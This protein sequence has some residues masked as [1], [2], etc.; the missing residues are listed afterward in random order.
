MTHQHEPTRAS[1]PSVWSLPFGSFMGLIAVNGAISLFSFGVFIKPLE[2]EFGWDRASISSAIALCAFASALSVPLVGTLMDRFGVR[3]VMIT[4]I[5]LF[6]AN[7]AAIGLSGS[8]VTFVLLTA[9]T[10]VTGVGQGPIGYVKSISSYFDRYR[11]IAIGIAISG[12]GVGTAFVPLYTQWLIGHVGW[13]W[14]YA[15]LGLVLIA[16]AWPAV[17]FFIREPDASPIA[18]RARAR[19]GV[20][21]ALPGATAREA[22]ASRTFWILICTIFFVSTVVNGSIVHVVS[23]L[24]DR[25][26]SAEAAA[27]IMVWVG[28]AS[29]VGRLVVGYLL[30]RMFAPYVAIGL[31]LA[32]L[33]GLYLL[34]SGKNAYLG[35]SGIGLTGG[36]EIDVI[37]YM[38]S[39]YFGLRRFGQI[40]GYQFGVFLVGAGLGP[41]LMGAAQTR[42]HSY[43]LPFQA[44][45]VL[46]VLASLL[47]LLMGGYTYPTEDL[48]DGDREPPAFPAVTAE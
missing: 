41:M 26:W 36:A 34:A 40:Y 28:L 31:F 22:I 1:G 5:F 44:F 14:A 27:A 25:G 46:L 32:A 48:R 33:G 8:I 2:A 35:V 30:D 29:M 24:T 20:T 15:G 19:A 6:A 37:A 42:L 12:T 39:R 23:L 17:M 43:D 13:R 4:S 9:L 11:G 38:V 21:A 47:M 16:L 18:H 45:G 10:G 3:R 7:V